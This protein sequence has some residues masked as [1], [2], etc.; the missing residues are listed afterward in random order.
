MEFCPEVLVGL[1]H[2]S[3]EVVHFDDD[4]EEDQEG[5]EDPLHHLLYPS[6]SFVLAQ[7]HIQV[8]PAPHHYVLP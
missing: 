3:R 7:F 4:G 1:H 5:L 8:Q 6:H 2:A